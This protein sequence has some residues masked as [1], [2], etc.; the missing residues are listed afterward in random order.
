[1]NSLKL[2]N[3]EMRVYVASMGKLFRVTAIAQSDE[4]ANEYCAGH[5]GQGVIAED[6]SGLIYIADRY[7][8]TCPTALI[9]NY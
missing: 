9:D 5:D 7:G 8:H 3:P 1:M 6:K 2:N 4:E